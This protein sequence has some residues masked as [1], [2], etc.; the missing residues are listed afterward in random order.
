M[1]TKFPTKGTLESVVLAY[2]FSLAIGTATIAAP[3]FTCEVESGAEDAS[4]LSV[5]S[6]D[7]QIDSGNAARVLQRVVG[8]V[9]G[10]DYRIQCTVTTSA[11]DTLTLAAILPVRAKL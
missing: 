1:T 2:D 5:L 11:G 4:P 10:T 3:S 6:G 8:G 7:P 9:D